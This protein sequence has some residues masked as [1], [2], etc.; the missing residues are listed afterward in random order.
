MERSSRFP[1]SMIRSLQEGRCKHTPALFPSDDHCHRQVPTLTT[2]W[3]IPGVLGK[4]STVDDSSNI[5]LVLQMK[6]WGSQ[7]VQAWLTFFADYIYLPFVDW[8]QAHN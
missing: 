3:Y 8:F 4:K 5:K 2:K 6:K 7:F 1:D